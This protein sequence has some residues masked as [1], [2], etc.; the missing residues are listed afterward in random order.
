MAIVTPDFA[1]PFGDFKDFQE[2]D[3]LLAGWQARYRGNEEC[4]GAGLRSAH[5]PITKAVIRREMAMP[6]SIVNHV[7]S[8]T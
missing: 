8:E 6:A 3:R 2:P 5:R 1:R 7:S 4:L